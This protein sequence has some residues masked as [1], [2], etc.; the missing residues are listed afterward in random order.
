MEIPP[1]TLPTTPPTLS[2]SRPMPGSWQVGQLL[3]AQVLERLDGARVV[4]AIQRLHPGS[5]LSGQRSAPTQVE[6]RTPVPLAPRQALTLEV[7]KAGPLPELRIVAGIENESQITAAQAR[8]TEAMRNALPRQAPLAETLNRLFTLGHRDPAAL[9]PLV[10]H[11]LQHLLATLPQWREARNAAGL[12]TAMANSGLWLENKLLTGAKDPD[13]PR[14]QHDLKANLLRLL[15]T[16]G[17]QTGTEEMAR[18][19]ETALAR[20]QTH[21]IAALTS[22]STGIPTWTVELPLKRDQQVDVFHLHICRDGGGSDE[23]SGT[24]WSVW[25]R[26]DL[27]ALGPVCVKLTLS[28]STLSARW[29]VERQD[30]IELVQRYLPM[31]ADHFTQ[32]GLSVGSM[33][34]QQ[35]DAP[36]PPAPTTQTVVDIRA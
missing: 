27:A 21:Q 32:A 17:K 18:L 24:Q 20:V 4:L 13:A 22:E 10:Q 30:T 33:R 14:L 36:P 31:L 23:G 28:N 25:L 35:G 7:I 1:R 3:Q 34:C 11:A 29:W 19:V 5:A 26:F 9:V 6:A 15:A 2:A 12:R 16:L 8:L